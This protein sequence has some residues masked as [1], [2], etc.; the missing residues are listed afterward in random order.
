ML[1]NV[2]SLALMQ[3]HYQTTILVLSNCHNQ[4]H[5]AILMS[6]SHLTSPGLSIKIIYWP[7]LTNPSI[8]SGEP[9]QNIIQFK[10]RRNYILA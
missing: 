9:Y 7:M 6:S 2:Y 4:T 1:I 3:N 10:L 5:I 8:F